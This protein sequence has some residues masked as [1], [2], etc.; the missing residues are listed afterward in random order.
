MHFCDKIKNFQNIDSYMHL[1]NNKSICVIAFPRQKWLYENAI[2]LRY[3]YFILL[4]INTFLQD[5]I[6]WTCVFEA[7]IDVQ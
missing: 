6:N 5:M 7:Y 3:T 1:R 4:G 2:P